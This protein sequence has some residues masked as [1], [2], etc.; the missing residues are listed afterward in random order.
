[1]PPPLRAVQGL[2]PPPVCC[3]QWTQA[4][5]IWSREGFSRFSTPRHLRYQYT[6]LARR[7]DRLRLWTWSGK[8]FGAGKMD[9]CD[10][11][12][13][14]T[15]NAPAVFRSCPPAFILPCHLQSNQ[16]WGLVPP[17]GEELGSRK[18]QLKPQ[19]YIN[20]HSNISVVLLYFKLLQL[21]LALDLSEL[22]GDALV[23]DGVE[24]LS[25]R[26]H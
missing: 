6:D 26:R 25:L 16:I 11:V 12:G 7:K 10:L 15:R 20:N 23:S 18:N 4:S 2:L 1:M 14:Q 17:Q 9:T 24:V 8:K 22:D 21:L 3:S 5:K 19:T 13:F